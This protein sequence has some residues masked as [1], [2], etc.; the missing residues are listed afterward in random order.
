MNIS[1]VRPIMIFFTFIIAGVIPKEKPPLN[2]VGEVNGL[3][4]F[5]IVRQIRIYMY[6]YI[7]HVHVCILYYIILYCVT[8][9]SFRL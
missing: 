7:I 8:A 5:L 4:A 9:L 3:I 2:V 1:H 6:M